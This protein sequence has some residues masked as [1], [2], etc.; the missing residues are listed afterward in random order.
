[1]PP[2]VA[3]RTV[4]LGGVA[5]L[6]AVATLAITT[7]STRGKKGERFPHPVRWYKAHAAPYGP[8]PKHQRT[9]CGQKLDAS[10]LGVAHP[11]LPCGSKIFIEYDHRQ[12]LTQVIDHGRIVPGRD[13][14]VTEALARRIG[15]KGTQQIRWAFAG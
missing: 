6:A 14:D 3:L 7:G 9:A 2:D 13:F 15:L 4:A 5:L 11:V 12:V 10:T 1:M 8:T